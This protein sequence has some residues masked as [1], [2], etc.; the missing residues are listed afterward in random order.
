M[1][2]IRREQPFPLRMLALSA[3]LFTG[4]S[5]GIAQA[6]QGVQQQEA[7]EIQQKL[8]SVSSKIEQARAEASKK[9]K[10]K[11]GL[12]EYNKVLSEKMKEIDSSK[13]DEV[14]R[15]AELFKQIVG[16]EDSSEMSADD[17][18][19]AREINQEFSE[20][21]QNLMEVAREANQSVEVQDAFEAY[22]ETLEKEMK[23]VNP[24]V[25]GQLKERQ[26]LQ[27]QLQKKQS[28]S[29]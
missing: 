22:N 20:V 3:L 28:I 18:E 24:E 21:R 15:R 7:M 5:L 8:Q 13:A 29:Q 10:V 27:Q 12:L 16:L 9:E 26:E 23:A 4:A 14:D 6:Q 1:N 2:A 25:E 11:S 19:E 17:I